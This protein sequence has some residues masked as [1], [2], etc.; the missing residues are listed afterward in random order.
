M[1]T[2]QIQENIFLSERKQIFMCVAE[3]KRQILVFCEKMKKNQQ[4]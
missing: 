4:F 2:E 3:E 1:V